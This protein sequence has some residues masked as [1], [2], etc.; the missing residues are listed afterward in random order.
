MKTP[1][2]FAD[3]NCTDKDKY[4]VSGRVFNQ[5]AYW[6]VPEGVTAITIEPYWGKAVYLSDAYWDVTYKNNGND[7]MATAANVP[8]VGGGQR[9]ENGKKY[10]LATQSIDETNGQIVYT[11]MSNAIASSGTA[12]FADY[13]DEERNSHSVYDYAV[14]LVGN[15]HF[16]GTLE[17]SNS[18]PYTVTSIDLDG[19]NE[20]DYSYILR[21]NSRIRVHPVRIDFLTAIGLGMAQKTTGEGLIF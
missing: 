15:Y 20:P 11:S 14:V 21:F 10:N 17:A 3:R 2:N 6:D 19:D 4:G 16:N 18:K 7:A 8:N 1:Y 13:T 5:G 12:L 9:Y